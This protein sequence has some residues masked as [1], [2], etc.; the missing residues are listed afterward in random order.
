MRNSMNRYKSPPEFVSEI[1]CPI[2]PVSVLNPE[3][4]PLDHQFKYLCKMD[5]V[6][7]CMMGDCCLGCVLPHHFSPDPGYVL[8]VFRTPKGFSFASLC[9]LCLNCK[10][11]MNGQVLFTGVAPFQISKLT[12]DGGW[13]FTQPPQ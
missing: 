13:G 7:L 1:V 9:L 8:P 4:I 12:F 2:P 5:G 10:A 11:T 6:E 3:F